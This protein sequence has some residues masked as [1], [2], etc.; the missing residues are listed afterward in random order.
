MMTRIKYFLLGLAMAQGLA[1]AY[2]QAGSDVEVS[3]LAGLAVGEFYRGQHDRAAEVL[4]SLARAEKDHTTTLA[5]FQFERQD[6]A[7]V[8]ATLAGLLD[9]MEE[10]QRGK[11][12]HWYWLARAQANQAKWDAALQS[13]QS[14]K[15]RVLDPEALRL[16][17]EAVEAGGQVQDAARAWED[18]VAAAGHGKGAALACLKAARF[19]HGQGKLERAIELYRKAEELDGNYTQV[20]E[21]LAA[22]YEN[23][24]KS[25]AARSRLERAAGFDRRYAHLGRELSR[26]EKKYP[27]LKAQAEKEQA[28]KDRSR[29]KKPNVRVKPLNVPSGTPRVSVG[30]LTRAPSF[31]F[32]TGGPMTLYRQQR[33]GE[34]KKSS[35][36]LEG[37]EIYDVALRGRKWRLLHVSEK[38]D[39][40]SKVLLRFR[41][42]IRLE[43]DHPESTIRLFD[44]AHGAGYFWASTE[45]RYYRG[46]LELYPRGVKGVTVI[47]RVNMEEYLMGVVPSEIPPTWPE[48]ALKAQAI[49]ARTH[50]WSTRGRFR[51][52]GFDLC[53]TQQC[54][55]YRGVTVEHPA[56]NKAVEETMGQVLENPATQKLLPVFYMS[57]SGGHTQ[58][59]GDAWKWNPD[60][61]SSAVFDG[62]GENP[63]ADQFPL[64]P[65]L[66]L[67]WLEDRGHWPVES[68]SRR[69]AR[70]RPSNFRW[71]MQYDAKRLDRFVSR[72]HKNI[73]TLLKVEPL[74]RSKAGYV[75]QV[76]FTGTRGSSIGSSDY[77]R[78]AIKG[79]KSSMFYVETRLGKDGK[80]VE[81][82]F[83][84][85]GWGHGVGLCQTGAAGMAE[86]SYSGEQILTHYFPGGRIRRRY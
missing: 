10:T 56:T 28:A 58:D 12:Q 2:N 78:S 40:H 26:L 64:R 72:R 62:P 19:F 51:K 27:R 70:E 18:A 5:A 39:H 47:N 21:P 33:N 31:K 14:W 17:A 86:Q 81:F 25:D 71:T 45:D 48:E 85:G 22:I 43:Q 8:E 50:A 29:F 60:V 59:P 52:E 41:E 83:H 4:H 3:G 63:Y 9:G 66:L 34:W 44:V 23:Q 76:R 37:G 46:D 54:A 42:K 84:G 11:S 75:K 79:L 69:P 77:I 38:G 7:A 82:L 57:N 49:A 16:Y 67:N 61:P 80:P 53:P 13:L 55:V 30:L 32:R 6:Y 74:D 73:G 20:H 15:D 65:D 1:L 36:R 24:G 35:V 68:Y